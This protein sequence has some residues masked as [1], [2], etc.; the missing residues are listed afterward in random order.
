MG[1]MILKIMLGYRPSLLHTPVNNTRLHPI[2]VVVRATV[3]GLHAHR[4]N[5]VML[6]LQN[7]GYN[8]CL[9]IS[10]FW[11]IHGA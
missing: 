6:I 1:F 7:S 4:V 5:V 10:P 2:I 8:C 9:A 3:V 11:F